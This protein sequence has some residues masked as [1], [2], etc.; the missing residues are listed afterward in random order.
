MPSPW[1]SALVTGASSGIGR[2]I[3]RELGL[4]GTDLVL[5]ARDVDRLKSLADEIVAGARGG[6]SGG[7]AIE[8][9]GADLADPAQ[10]ATVEAR[11]ADAERPVD[12]LV[13][14]AGFGTYGAFADLPIDGEE[15]EIRVNV[16]AV[17]RLAHAALAAMRD[18][19]EG[20]IVNVSSVAGLQATPGNATYGATK[21]FVASFGE[22]LHEEARQVG[23]DVTTVLPGFTRTEFQERAG[24]DAPGHGI[25]DFLW[26]DAD[27]VAAEA[28]AGAAK[29]KAVVVCG[30]LNRATAVVTGP[31]PRGMKRRVVSAL[32]RRF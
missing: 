17:V 28:L 9:L 23:V 20:T 29:G 12:L 24:Y 32:A 13:N 22:A 2:E 7:P 14:N 5:V 1:K 21:A 25:P 6:A 11:L 26:Q 19:G 10:L 3:A 16:V 18:R 15:A 31:F 4:S 27:A 30:P 8:V